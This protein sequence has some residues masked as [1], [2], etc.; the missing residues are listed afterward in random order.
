LRQAKAVVSAV[1]NGTEP[2]LRVYLAKEYSGYGYN[3]TPAEIKAEDIEN[4][5]LEMPKMR[6]LANGSLSR[7]QYLQQEGEGIQLLDEKDILNFY[8]IF[9]TIGIFNI[10]N[11]VLGI[12]AA[13][14]TAKG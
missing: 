7:E 2:E 6:Q 14:L 11:I 10:I 9:R 5:K 3:V 12:G 8:V 4:L 1:P 13:F